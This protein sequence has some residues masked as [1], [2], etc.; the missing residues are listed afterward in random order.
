MDLVA[1]E[2]REKKRRCGKSTEIVLVD[3]GTTEKPFK[4]H[5]VNSSVGGIAVVGGLLMLVSEG[6]SE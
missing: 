2:K 6:R 1:V 5:V 3:E 4:G